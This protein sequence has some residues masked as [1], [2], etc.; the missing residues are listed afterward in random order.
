[1]LSIDGEDL[2]PLPLSEPKRRLARIMPRIESRLMFPDPIPAR[3]RRLF[4]LV[5]ERD[6][7]GIIARW[8]IGRHQCDGRGTSW[9]KIQNPN[10]SQAEGRHELIAS[11]RVEWHRRG[12]KTSAPALTPRQTTRFPD[13]R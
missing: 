5:C 10:S 9:L 3:G 7:E 13:R 12:R 4:E 8:R 2:R 11:K 1:V 6:L